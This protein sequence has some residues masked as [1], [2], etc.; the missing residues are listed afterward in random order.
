MDVRTLVF[1]FMLLAETNEDDLLESTV[2]LL[3]GE[4]ILLSVVAELLASLE[5]VVIGDEDD[6]GVLLFIA[7]SSSFV[8]L[9]AFVDSL[10]VLDL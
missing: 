5:V 2:R 1:T 8:S 6:S 10:L 4:L 7:M 9:V 3:L